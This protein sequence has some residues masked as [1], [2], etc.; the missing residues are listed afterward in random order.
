MP[1]KEVDKL[2]IALSGKTAHSIP[3]ESVLKVLGDSYQII[4]QLDSQGTLQ[5]SVEGASFS[6]PLTFDISAGTE[7]TVFDADALNGFIQ[8]LKH[9]QG[10][11]PPP[12]RATKRVIAKARRVA[13]VLN[14]G[15]G[16][17]EFRTPRETVTVQKAAK[18][19]GDVPQIDKAE[20]ED[21]TDIEGT[22]EVVS[23]HKK[24]HIVIWDRVIS[25][26]KTIGVVS[27]AIFVKAL[28]AMKHDDSP[29]VSVYGKAQYRKGLPTTINVEEFDVLPGL[30]K[31]RDPAF[32]Q[33]INITRGVDSVDYI[34]SLR[35]D[36]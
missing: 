9:V 23:T 5:L 3:L 21:W 34:R 11:G 12:R 13:A 35:D 26:H 32:F 24:K 18:V 16:S 15:V 1:K 22:L 29:R 28:E 4:H 36:A 33:G 8:V 17:I 27:H 19:A 30:T 25:N 7:Y 6:S 14:D 20:Y 2:T 10:D 31:A